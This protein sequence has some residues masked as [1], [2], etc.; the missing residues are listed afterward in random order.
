MCCWFYKLKPDN[1]DLGNLGDDE[2]GDGEIKRR[3]MG[4]WE[5]R[6]S[7]K[8]RGMRKTNHNLKDQSFEDIVNKTKDLG[9]GNPKGSHFVSI[10]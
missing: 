9:P 8:R 7:R 5:R 10:T 6:L 1:N 3:R 4:G 2:D